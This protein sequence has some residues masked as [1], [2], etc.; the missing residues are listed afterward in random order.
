MNH[1]AIAI[2]LIKCCISMTLKERG[3]NITR[4]TTDKS[5]TILVKAASVT[6]GLKNCIY[7][8]FQ[9]TY[10]NKLSAGKTNHQKH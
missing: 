9:V 8:D 7:L 6:S 2:K 1:V 10:E 5:Q 4:T 3:V